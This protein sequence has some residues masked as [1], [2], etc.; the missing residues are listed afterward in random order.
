MR[1]ADL[2][3]LLNEVGVRPNRKLGQNFLVDDNISRW[4]VDQLRMTPNDVV[5]EVGPGTGALT[6][7]LIGRCR[8]L[9]LIEKDARLAG[10]LDSHYRRHGWHFE[11]LTEDAVDFDVRPLFREG[12]IKLIGNLPY[13]SATE[14][15]RTFLT[16]PSPVEIAVLMV[17]KEVAQRICAEPRSKAYGVL[18]LMLQSQWNPQLIKTV[19]PPAFFPQPEVESSIL[20]FTP[21]AREE[22]PEFS[23]QQFDQIVRKGFGQRRKQLRNNLGIE[24]PK[25]DR[26]ARS[27]NF[28][29]TARAEELS[30]LQWI[31]LSNRLDRHPGRNEAQSRDEV[32]DVVDS[33]DLMIEKVTRSEVHRR[34][35]L[36]R[37]VHIFVINRK[38]EI[39]LQKRSALKDMHAG[40]WDSSAAGHLESGED[41]AHAAVRELKEELMIRVRKP[42]VRLGKLKASAPTDWEFVELYLCEFSGKI[43]THGNEIECGGFFDLGEVADWVEDRPQ[44]FATG[45]VECFRWYVMNVVAG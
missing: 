38:G 39:Y 6:K 1:M 12:G 7:H 5:V 21:R 18:S 44:D 28:P 8:R 2:Q 23:P 19:K 35:L 31:N 17:Q 33:N 37:A 40:K 15:M 4:I 13:S 22:F 43:R 36:H 30:L 25:W 20:C 10:W 16:P 41:Y 3:K 14:I 11:V 32:F 9:V 45:F 34:K 27:V 26:L 24:K 29:P 42:L